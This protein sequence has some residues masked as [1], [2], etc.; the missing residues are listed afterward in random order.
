MMPSMSPHRLAIV[1]AMAG[2]IV[3]PSG[4]RAQAG[5]TGAGE[6][7][8]YTGLTMGSF[9]AHPVVGASS[10]ISFSRYSI[11]LFD[12][13]FM[14]LDSDTL[15]YLPGRA[16]QHSGL[17]D[18]NFSAHLRVPLRG[19]RW[20][21][22]GIVGTAYLLSTFRAASINSEGIP[23]Y[24]GRTQTNFGFET[25]GGVRY[26]AADTWGIRTELRYTLSSRNFTRLLVG[27]FYQ[28]DG[29][30]FFRWRRGMRN[31]GRNGRPFNRN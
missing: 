26:Y 5:E 9:S 8:G 1:F 7:S 30:T 12:A 6:F 29:E 25:G 17:Y 28:F 22:Y 21:P 3:D 11:V 15:R 20:E 27:V 31:L 24:V 19:E 23:V 10:G 18:L 2:L 13:S 14:P 16:V 4:L